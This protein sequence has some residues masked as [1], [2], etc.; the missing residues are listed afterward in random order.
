[1]Y[2]TNIIT[3]MIVR[4]KSMVAFLKIKALINSPMIRPSSPIKMIVPSFV[5]SFF[6]VYPYNAIKAKITAVI[7]KILINDDTL[8]AT[9]IMENVIPVKMQYTMY[10]ILVVIGF[11]F[12]SLIPSI[13]AIT[14][15]IIAIGRTPIDKM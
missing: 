2:P 7:I 6:V 3:P 11:I 1:M 15:S 4:P 10:S 5:R 14:I 12:C 13:T 9:K 8:N